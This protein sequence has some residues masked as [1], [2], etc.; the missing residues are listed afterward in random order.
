MDFRSS[1]QNSIGAMRSASISP[2]VQ[3]DENL[4]DQQLLD[5]L[6]RERAIRYATGFLPVEMSFRSSEIQ[7]LEISGS[8]FDSAKIQEHKNELERYR[9][10][11]SYIQS[12]Y[13]ESFTENDGPGE[14]KN[15]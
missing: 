4:T 14:I 6:P 11:M 7:R 5:R 12:K 15:R 8:P 3:I 10:A 2:V 13:P 9:F 1:K